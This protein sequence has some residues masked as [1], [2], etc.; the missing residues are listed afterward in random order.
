MKKASQAPAASAVAVLIDK[1]Y[2]ANT[3]LQGVAFPMYSFI[4]EGNGY[5]Y[6]DAITKF[7]LKADGTPM[8]RAERVD[9]AV[10]IL[11]AAGHEAAERMQLSTMSCQR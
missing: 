2:I 3:L 11:D 9:E 4:P 10:R 1:E 5:W 6:S 8:S 7:G